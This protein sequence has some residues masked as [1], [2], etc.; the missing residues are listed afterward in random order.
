MRHPDEWANATYRKTPVKMLPAAGVHFNGP[1]PRPGP[2]HSTDTTCNTGIVARPAGVGNR[3]YTTHR[4]ANADCAELQA[5]THISRI[6]QGPI[7][8]DMPYHAMT[9]RRP[10]H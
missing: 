7:F 8:P 9:S 6:P 10:V 2:C 3:K 5:G 4:D 1:I